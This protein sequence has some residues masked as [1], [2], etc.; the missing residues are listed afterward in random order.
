M[1]ELYEHV[2]RAGEGL[3]EVAARSRAGEQVSWQGKNGHRIASADVLLIQ[4]INHATE[5]RTHIATILSQLGIEPPDM[6][7]WMYGIATGAL[8]EG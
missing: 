1:A 2:R 8:R 3:V 6:S 5:H 7:G 4:A